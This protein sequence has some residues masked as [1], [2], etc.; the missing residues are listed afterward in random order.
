MGG[1][2]QPHRKQKMKNGCSYLRLPLSGKPCHEEMLLLG[3][4]GLRARPD[5]AIY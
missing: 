1:L 5:G 3:V 2:L 4:T